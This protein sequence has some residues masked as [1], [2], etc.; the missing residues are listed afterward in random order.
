MT[1][2]NA[3]CDV[4]FDSSVWYN[5]VY[6]YSS[7]H[8]AL[9]WHVEINVLAG[10]IGTCQHKGDLGRRAS[11]RKHRWDASVLVGGLGGPPAQMLLR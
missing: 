7:Y 10:G 8:Y 11:A 3:S 9:C 6:N 1:R 5:K 2:S 4:P